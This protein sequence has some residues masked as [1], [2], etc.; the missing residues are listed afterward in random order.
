MSA[1][2]EAW[3]T[4]MSKNCRRMRIWGRRHRFYQKPPQGFRTGQIVKEKWNTV[5]LGTSN[6]DETDPVKLV[7]MI[8]DEQFFDKVYTYFFFCN[9]LSIHSA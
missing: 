5:Q 2:E 4:C 8:A 9:P 6:V 7:E 1:W 3:E